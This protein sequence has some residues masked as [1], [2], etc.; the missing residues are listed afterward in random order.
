MKAEL[1]D[2]IVI[3]DIIYYMNCCYTNLPARLLSDQSDP[4]IHKRSG[5]NNLNSAALHNAGIFC[6]YKYNNTAVESCSIE[7]FTLTSRNVSYNFPGKGSVWVLWNCAV[8]NLHRTNQSFSLLNCWTHCLIIF[9]YCLYCVIGLLNSS[10]DSYG[11]LAVL[12]SSTKR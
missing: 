4:R 7:L 6:C 10:L 3:V 2:G 8:G 12:S 1:T 5:T 11:F 9:I